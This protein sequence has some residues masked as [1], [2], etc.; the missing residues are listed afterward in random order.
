M[1]NELIYE[2]ENRSVAAKGDRGR[3]RDGLGVGISKCKQLPVE[4][5]KTR[6]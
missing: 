5:I 3:G 6:S 4:W 1:T 2:T